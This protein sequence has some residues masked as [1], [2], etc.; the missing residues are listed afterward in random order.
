MKIHIIQCDERVQED[1][2]ITEE[3]ELKAYMEHLEMKGGGGTD[4]RPAF[5]YIAEL[6]ERGEF[7][8]LRGVLY[9]TDGPGNLSGEKT[10]L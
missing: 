9:F 10:T 5:E 4:F 3:K 6:L 8:Q 2:R 1:I 7:E